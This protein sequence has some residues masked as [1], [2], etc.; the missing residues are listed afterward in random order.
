MLVRFGSQ[1]LGETLWLRAML[2]KGWRCGVLVLAAHFCSS[3]YLHLLGW[4]RNLR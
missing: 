4:G 2:A 3:Q 1:R